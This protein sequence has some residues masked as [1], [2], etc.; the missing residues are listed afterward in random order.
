MTARIFRFH[1]TEADSDMPL[2]PR[3]FF[4]T[5]PQP[6]PLGDDEREQLAAEE[7]PDWPTTRRFARTT[8]GIDAAF[9]HDD[10]Y[11]DPFERSTR[12]S[13]A[14]Q[15][16]HV[17]ALSHKWVDRCIFVICAGVLIAWMLGAFK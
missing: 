8:H 17:E 7:F 1:G 12:A 16:N 4:V 11:T 2:V 14:E 3:P 10:A 15:D 13:F 9:R 6:E 5:D